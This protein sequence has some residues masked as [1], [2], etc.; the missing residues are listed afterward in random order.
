MRETDQ[1]YGRF[2]DEYVS[3][4]AVR[5]YTTQTAG[6]G[7]SYLLRHDYADI[8]LEAV[9]TY[10]SGSHARPLR[11]LE[12]GCGGGMNL[13]RLVSV[14]EEGRNAV[15]CAYGTDF[16]PRLVE[17]AKE[18]AQRYLPAGLSGKVN[19]FVARNEELEADLLSALGT[20]R[21]GLGSFDLILGVNTFRYC[22]RLGKQL[23]CAKDIYRLLR[24]GGVCVNIDMNNRFPVFRS[25]FSGPKQDPEE[26]YLPTLAQYAEPFESA[27]FEIKE[28]RNFCWVPHSA[29]RALTTAACLAAPFLN[30]VA[31][32][33]AMRSL[34]VARRPS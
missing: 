12:F 15:E 32:K 26:T 27:G 18:E 28:R 33:R 14:L 29:G 24:P 25:R 20:D 21:D 19:F 30:L 13:T 9:R 16:S 1:L 34:V 4:Q 2:L 6:F 10:L 8:Y 7:I 17:A 5:K 22:H 23:D 11:I 31:R 3:E